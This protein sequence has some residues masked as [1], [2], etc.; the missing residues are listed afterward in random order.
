VKAV[1]VRWRLPRGLGLGLAAA[2]LGLAVAALPFGQNLEEG[3]GLTWLFRLRGPETPPAEVAIVSIDRESSQRL[4]LPDNP[5]DWPRDI[6][7]RLLDRLNE[8]GARLVVFDVLFKGPR[9]PAGDRKLADAVRRAG[10]VIL[11]EFIRKEIVPMIGGDGSMGDIVTEQRVPPFPALASSALGLAPFVLPRVPIEVHQ[12]WLYKPEAG[13]AATLPVVALQAL[14]PESYDRILEML[15]QLDPSTHQRIVRTAP[16]SGR[17]LRSDEKAEMLRRLFSGSPETAHRLLQRLGGAARS[18]VSSDGYLAA[19][20]A[21]LVGPDSIYL[22][23]YGPPRTIETIPYYQVLDAA[24]RMDPKIA[25]QVL[26]I[27]AAPRLQPEQRDGFYTPFTLESGL[28]IGGVEIAA[29]AFANLLDRSRITPL[30][31]PREAMLLLF[32]GLAIGLIL[33]RLSGAL[34]PPAAAG[35]GGVY[36]AVAYAAFAMGN[37]WL[38]L[39]T[40]LLV[41]LLPATFAAILLRHRDLQ[42]E[43]ERIRQAFGMHLPLPIV[44]QLARGIGDFET[45]TEHAFGICLAT[46]AEQYTT[47]SEALEPIVLKQHLNAYYEALFFPVRSRGGVITDVVGDSMLAIWVADEDRLGLRRTACEAALEI[48]SAVE[49]FNRGAPDRRLPTRLGLHCGDLVLGHVGAMDHY[50][51]RAVGG[52]VNTASRIEGLCKRLGTELLA[53]DEVVGGLDGLHVRPLGRFL[54]KGKTRPLRISELVPP[55]RVDDI[56]LARRWKPFSEGLEAFRIGDW[57]GALA[58][59][60]AAEREGGGDGPSAFYRR[61]CHR[62]LTEPPTGEWTGIVRLLEK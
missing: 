17:R 35:M 10:N 31:P 30:P 52:I 39:V 43:R 58:C 48:L 60:E 38:P 11:F 16:R 32:W 59:F 24:S 40:P 53:S 29:T 4:G 51:Y 49:D 25:G 50:E 8:A 2:I 44:D 27:G 5:R 62:Y 36:L 13:G 34:I 37:L 3:F 1:L 23:Y 56:L 14:R 9:G 55:E 20:V 46:D 21:A 61:L 54:L 41:Q 6:H 7:A 45:S 19:L 22:N 42:R 15:G 57:K 18:G 12:V 47:L 26:F 33:R 28:D